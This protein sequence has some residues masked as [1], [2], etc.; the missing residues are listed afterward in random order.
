MSEDAAVY[1][2]LPAA[3]PET[4]TPARSIREQILRFEAALAQLPGATVGDTDT[5]PLTH[6]F[7]DGCY[8]RQIFIPAGMMLTGKIH[9][10]SH[11]NFLMLGEVLVATEFGGVEHLRAPLAMISQAGTKRAVYALTDTWWITVHVTAERDLARIEEHVIAPDY[12]SFAAFQAAR[13]A[14]EEKTL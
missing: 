9:K 2:R 4:A 10:H 8:V 3:P 12:P 6:S 14:L 7:A 11:P 13:L 5:L 1:E